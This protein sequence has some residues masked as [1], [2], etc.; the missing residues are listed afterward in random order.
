MVLLSICLP[1][2]DRK[3]LLKKTLL[4][5]LEQRAGLADPAAVEI[6][7]SDNASPDGTYRMLEELKAQNAILINKNPR[8][9]GPALNLDAAIK[10]ASGKYCWLMGDDDF[11][12]PGALKKI[13]TTVSEH[14]DVA[15]FYVNYSQPG[16][17]EPMV[18]L[19]KD[20]LF[21]TGT[22]YV[23]YGL[24][25][26]DINEWDSA[27]LTFYP[28]MIVDRRRWFAA[29]ASSCPYTPQAHIVHSFLAE[30]PVYLIAEPLLEQ[31]PDVSRSRSFLYYWIRLYWFMGR[32]YGR[33]FRF[34]LIILRLCLGH[35]KYRLVKGLKKLFAPRKD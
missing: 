15:F 9:L 11:I 8:N 14:P 21:R 28:N 25:H 20:L 32:M 23:D 13:V 17:A 19:K 33:R 12:F 26:F 4:N 35:F 18:R 29:G 10:M 3:E 27:K 24:A 34:S 22:E 6:A 2:F 7:V 1:T 31:N 30:V 16:R 5:L